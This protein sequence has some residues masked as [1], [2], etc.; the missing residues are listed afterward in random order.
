MGKTTNFITYNFIAFT[1]YLY[2]DSIKCENKFFSYFLFQWPDCTLYY[3]MN[4]LTWIVFIWN[5]RSATCKHFFSNTYHCIY[6]QNVSIND[7]ETNDI[8]AKIKI[9]RFLKYFFFQYSIN[10]IFLI[11]EKK[12]NGLHIFKK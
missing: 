6:F 1:M 10:A 12:M 8:D 5:S 11:A 2:K 4:T 7:W 9:S 3:I